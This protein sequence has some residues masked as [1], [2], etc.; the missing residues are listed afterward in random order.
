M[1]SPDEFNEW[2]QFST[3]SSIMEI[4]YGLHIKRDDPYVGNVEKALQGINQAGVPGTFLVETFPVMRH[5]PS[6]LPGVGWKRRALYW[7]DV[8]RE[9]RLKPFNLIRGQVNE[10]NAPPSICRTLIKDLNESV[11]PDQVVKEDIAID[12]CAVSFV[13]ASETTLAAT[14]VFFLA[15]R[16]YPEVQRKGQAELDQV[17]NRRLPE[18]NDSPNLP[19]I[20]AIVKET[21]RWHP[22]APFSIPHVATDANEYNG[23]YIPKRTIVIGNAWS[24]LHDPEVYNDPGDYIPDRFLKDGQPDDSI[25][26]PSIAAFGY[27]RRICPGWYFGLDSLFL[28]IAHTLAV[29]DIKLALDE[30]GNEIQVKADF[31]SGLSSQPVPFQCSIKPRSE[32]A[33]ALIRNSEL[34]E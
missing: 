6:W 7:R 5:I 25:R 12:T 11:S 8:N 31:T 23:Y 26:D 27:G 10:G 34:V 20:N 4:I 30:H 32:A 29:F 15:M 2:I 1:K 3:A 21:L 22:V 18:L 24:L 28:I 16:L 13:G 19:Y 9:V 17:L 33:A 14:R